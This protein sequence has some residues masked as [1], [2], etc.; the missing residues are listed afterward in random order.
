[1]NFIKDIIYTNKAVIIKC[2]ELFKK[3]WTIIFTGLIYSSVTM[4]AFLLLTPFFGLPLLNIAAG[5]TMYFLTVSLTSSYFYILYNIVKYKKFE[6]KDMKIGL[7]VYLREV[8]RVLFIGWI[9]SILFFSLIL[10]ILG[11]SFEHILDYATI[12]KI[13]TI[14]V[15]VAINPL[16]EVIYQKRYTGLEGIKYAFDYMKENWVEWLVPNIILIGSLYLVTGRIITSLFTINI[17]LMSNIISLKEI[18]LYFLGQ[19][20]FSFT[21]IYRGILFEILSTSTRRKRM[22]KRN[23]HR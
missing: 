3:N 1:M 15:L 13:A 12:S 5:I 4:I 10:P 2:L 22:F 19:I 23:T 17:G 16:P 18:G 14:L 9:A 7:Q 21:M 11:G 20:I 8:S 6:F